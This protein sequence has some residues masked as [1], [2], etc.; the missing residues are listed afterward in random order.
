VMAV[1]AADRVSTYSCH[2]R[3]RERSLP[4]ANRRLNMTKLNSEIRELTIDELDTVSGGLKVGEAMTGSVTYF[5][6]KGALYT[7]TFYRAD[8]AVISTAHWSPA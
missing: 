5:E 1:T 8:G 6:G 7:S 3:R 2:H 4:D